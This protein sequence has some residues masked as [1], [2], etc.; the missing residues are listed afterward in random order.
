M[1]YHHTKG[2][3]F[4]AV[5]K[6]YMYVVGARMD[7]S[8]KVFTHNIQSD[9]LLFNY[10]WGVRG[11]YVCR[12]DWVPGTHSFVICKHVLCIH[13]LCTHIKPGSYR[14]NRKSDFLFFIYFWGVGGI[15]Y[16]DR[17]GH[18]APPIFTN[19]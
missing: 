4:G 2:H 6:K 16:A 3:G 1:S 14:R 15:T 8:V 9:F 19:K 11:H 18:L 12:Q 17:T 7:V 13:V 10:F 5:S